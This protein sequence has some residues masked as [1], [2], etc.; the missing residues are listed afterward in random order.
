MR[1]KEFL[2]EKID[3]LKM[4][5]LVQ[6]DESNITITK[7]GFDDVID[8]FYVAYKSFE[9]TLGGM[10]F[11]TFE[12]TIHSK[13]QASDFRRYSYV[14]KDGDKIIGGFYMAP[15]DIP[16]HVEELE[17]LRGLEGVCL[18]LLP[19]YKGRG[20]GRKLR[21]CPKLLKE[22]FD[23]IWGQHLASLDNLQNWV[24]FGNTHVATIDNV[25]ITYKL[26]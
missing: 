4:S 20:L 17:G 9:D 8:S 22:Q 14:M 26:L 3:E 5:N 25:H 2:S 10:S 19:E 23:Y 15:T 7:F 21:D 13:M 1:F 11:N 16:F 18:F 6:E 12:E 24:D